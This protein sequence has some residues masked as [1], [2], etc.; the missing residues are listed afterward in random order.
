[1]RIERIVSHSTQ[2]PRSVSAPW[3][4]GFFRHPEA[5]PL[6]E[7]IRSL[8][9]KHGRVILAGL[10]DHQNRLPLVI[11]ELKSN[12]PQIEVGV[13]LHWT[14]ALGTQSTTWLNI[15]SHARD[16]FVAVDHLISKEQADSI[17]VRWNPKWILIPKVGLDWDELITRR[18]FTD[19]RGRI[20]LWAPPADNPDGP[21]LST[22]ELMHHMRAMRITH[23]LID[24]VPVPDAWHIVSENGPQG[25]LTR[26]IYQV[27]QEAERTVSLSVIVPIRT[28]ADG[29]SKALQALQ[30]ALDSWQ[31]SYE[32]IV[33]LDDV[34]RPSDLPCGPNIRVLDLKR[35]NDADNDW[36]PGYV[37][38]YGA[39]ASKCRHDGLLLFCDA[40]I[41]VSSDFLSP[42]RSTTGWQF[43]QL[44]EG[45]T[46]LRWQSTTSKV[47]AIRRFAFESVGGFP[48]AFS[49]YGCE[50]NA[51]TWHLTR[52]RYVGLA[53]SPKTIVH[54][55]TKTDDD[56]GLLKMHRLRRSA[57]L[58][59]RMM[60]STEADAIYWHFFSALDD[61]DSLAAT[62]F[63]AMLKNAYRF[64]PI[65][66]LLAVT[67]F[68]L[69]LQQT[70]NR[71][72]YIR[73]VIEASTWKMRTQ[74]AKITPTYRI[75]DSL[76]ANLWK[77]PWMLAKPFHLIKANFWRAA[78]APQM[79]VGASRQN[80]IRIY[81]FA[82]ANL[83]RIPWTLAR[84]F[85]LIKANLWFFK[86]PYSWCRKNWPWFYRNI[87]SKLERSKVG[88]S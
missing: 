17:R 42:L 15:S 76:K 66:V 54:L 78:V 48:E 58:F 12:S 53:L 20:F 68:F 27:T 64:L 8:A 36:R 32:I 9:G 34:D 2:V 14:E 18:I 7:E 40:D 85:H 75:F 4:L 47:F 61:N 86:A 62:T 24:I 25:S 82:K 73:G 87:I 46:Q 29:A 44:A 56:D 74:F 3:T 50:D 39:A 45:P 16:V 6:L 10:S 28:F 63:R 13:L 83:W 84:P 59:Y 70:G 41:E 23:P 80:A 5:P 22:D 37:R 35:A 31:D 21:F 1:M 11:D 19:N 71:S 65:R 88:R 55:R 57:S 67:T 81:H 33:C 26:P 52:A 60:I 30:Q 43:A 49:H 79:F 69:T 72:A 38:N 77:I 51:L